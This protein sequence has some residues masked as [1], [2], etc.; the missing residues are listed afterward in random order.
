MLAI[1]LRV[2]LVGAFL[3]IAIVAVGLIAIFIRQASVDDLRL[4]VMERS[5]AGMM[6]AMTDHY[7]KD[8]SWDGALDLAYQMAGLPAPPPSKGRDSPPAPPPPGMFAILDERGNTV[9]PMPGMI[10]SQRVSPDIVSRGIPIVVDGRRVG[11]MI[12]EERPP[13]LGPDEQIYLD[14]TD[15]A[16]G[17]GSIGA[18]V[19]ALLVGY[20]LARQLT[21]PLLDLTNAAGAMASGDLEQEVRVRSRDEIGQLGTAFNLMSSE[22]AR[23]VQLRRQMTADVAHDLRTPL[24]VIAGYLEAMKNGDLAPTSAR[25]ELVYAEVEHLQQM[26]AD[27]GIMSRADAGE[28]RL[29]LRQ[30]HVEHVLGR[31]YDVHHHRAEQ[32]DIVL[33]IDE[34]SD[35][36]LI[37][38][39]EMR[40]A[41]VFNNLI[42]NALRHTLAGG[43]ITLSAR[44]SPGRVDLS[45]KDTGSGIPAEDLPHIFNRFYRGNKARSSGEGRSGLGLAIVHALVEAHGGTIQVESTVGMGTQFTVT[46]PATMV[47]RPVAVS[48]A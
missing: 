29:H 11:T 37:E 31:A 4:A 10:P 32:N 9:V 40:I 18:I 16:L 2:R 39:D 45:I 23:Q 35:D 42:D 26:V 21:R 27:L 1:S 8:Q 36:A 48:A 20:F 17:L 3:I 13:R 41:R 30:S 5:R 44:S 15:R 28:L 24:T 19:L 46:L 33:R 43:S 7:A 25:L 12:A 38:A 14:R 47:D 34:R 22:V 6:K